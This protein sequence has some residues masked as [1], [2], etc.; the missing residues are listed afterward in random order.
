[1]LAGDV[2]DRRAATAAATARAE[3]GALHFLDLDAECAQHVARRLVL[4]VVAAQVAGVVVGDAAGLA[5]AR[6]QRAGAQ[7]FVDEGAVV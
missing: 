5:A 7:Q 3:A 2:G 1:M 4:A 6:L